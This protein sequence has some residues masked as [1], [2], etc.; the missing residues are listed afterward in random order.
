MSTIVTYT[1]V[2]MVLAL[3]IGFLIGWILRRSTYKHRYEEN[4]DDVI[5]REENMVTQNHILSA[6]FDKGLHHL[7]KTKYDIDSKKSKLKDFIDTNEKL[8]TDIDDLQ[9]SEIAVKE[10]IEVLKVKIDKS[11][12]ELKILSSNSDN[13]LGYRNQ[14]ADYERKVE[15]KNIELNIVK[16][17]VSNLSKD[18][19]ALDQK[20]SNFEKNI[21]ELDKN[22]DKYENKVEKITDEFILRTKEI[23]GD[24]RLTEHKALNYKYAVD[25]VDEK[26]A[27]NE[28]IS[29]DTID[30]IINKNENKRSYKEIIIKLFTK[31]AEYIKGDK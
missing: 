23:Q 24:V 10:N 16:E 11:S 7:E 14:I 31:S 21:S 2:F 18:K 1:I 27:S 5:L 26:L 28:S 17:S 13:I 25:Y 4:I 6:E 8:N 15:E 30:K 22:I 29:A 3:L 12:G 20:I 19:E 9:N